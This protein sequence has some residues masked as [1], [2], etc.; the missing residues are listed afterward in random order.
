MTQ[1]TDYQ[2]ASDQHKDE[3]HEKGEKHTAKPCTNLDF[4]SVA[5]RDIKKGEEVTTTYG[6][7]YW[8]HGKVSEHDKAVV[9][10]KNRGRVKKLKNKKKKFQADRL[11]KW[12]QFL[13]RLSETYEDDTKAVIQEGLL[14][15]DLRSKTFIGVR[16]GTPKLGLSGGRNQPPSVQ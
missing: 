3:I 7:G 14:D 10:K 16:N 8:F 11:E 9:D 15:P 5:T 1:E 6:S 12:N 4:V 2:E 13:W